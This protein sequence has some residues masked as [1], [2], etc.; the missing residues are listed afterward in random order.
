MTETNLET[1]L[2]ITVPKG[3]VARIVSSE[4]TMGGLWIRETV[5]DPSKPLVVRAINVANNVIVVALG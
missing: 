2:M 5:Y 1:D 3:Y 4:S